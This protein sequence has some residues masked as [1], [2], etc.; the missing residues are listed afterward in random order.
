[1]GTVLTEFKIEKVEEDKNLIRITVTLENAKTHFSP[2]T[3][4]R[5]VKC[6]NMEAQNINVTKI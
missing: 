4:S 1:M 3:V 2:L 5:I 6:R